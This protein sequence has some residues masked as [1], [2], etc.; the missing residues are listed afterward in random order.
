MS[1]VL[2]PQQG[3]PR[4]RGTLLSDKQFDYVMKLIYELTGIA[5]TAA[6]RLLV[7]RRIAK[8]METIGLSDFED[9][10]A[11]LKSRDPVEVEHF[12]NAVTTNLTSFFRENHHFEF[13]KNQFIPEIRARRGE[14][15]LRLWSAGCSTGEEPYSI[16]ITLREAFQ[17]MDQWDVKILCTDL[18][19]E[20]LDKAS[21]GMYASE[22]VEGIEPARV[23]KWFQHGNGDQVKVKPVLQKNL[24]FRRLNLMHEWPFK[25]QFDLIF[26]RNVM[27]YF[28]KPTQEKLIKRFARHLVPSG[29]L[30][31]GH[32]ESLIRNSTQF[33]LLG[34]TVYQKVGR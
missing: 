3:E 2:N 6:K 31:V 32:S 22:R 24:V 28:D 21:R 7:E 17:E 20:V 29:Y 4:Q 34:H 33:E 8:R 1:G 25:G 19:S 27:I 18:D 9:Y 30:I 13:L 23:S 10:A 12:S 11:L 26:C 15:K 14:Q 16:A 5:M